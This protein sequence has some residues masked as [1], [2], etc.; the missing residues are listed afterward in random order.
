MKEAETIGVADIVTSKLMD[1]RKIMFKTKARR[2][3]EP[4]LL[5]Q[6]G[7]LRHRRAATGEEAHDETNGSNNQEYDKQDIGNLRGRSSNA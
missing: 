6:R 7:A 2:L 4:G 5:L 3:S 1:Q